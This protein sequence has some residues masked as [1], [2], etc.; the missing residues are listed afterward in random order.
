[1]NAT[2]EPDYKIV[3]LENH[4]H[5]QLIRSKLFLLNQMKKVLWKLYFFFIEEVKF[6][7]FKI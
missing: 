2:F 1:M 3:L 4:S 5:P 6:V 7:V